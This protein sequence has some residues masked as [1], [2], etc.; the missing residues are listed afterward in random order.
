MFKMYRREGG[1]QKTIQKA[2]YRTDFSVIVYIKLA[3]GPA[4]GINKILIF[5]LAYNTPVPQATH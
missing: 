1:G 5:L 2:F 4:H 3:E